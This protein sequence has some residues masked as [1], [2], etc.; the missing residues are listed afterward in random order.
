MTTDT[1]FLLD[2]DGPINGSNTGWS[3][4]PHKAWAYAK[5]KDKFY[6]MQ[7]SHHLIEKLR[8]FNIRWPETIYWATTWCGSTD[9]LERIFKLP[10]L[11]S[12]S[13]TAMSGDMKLRCAKMVI[14]NGDRLIWADDE[15]VPTSGSDYDFLTADG[16]ALLIKPKNS[17][18]RQG[19]RP[20]DMDNIFS[21]MERA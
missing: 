1:V 17:G 10:Q 19:I 20:E 21:F 6:K 18:R 8:E 15:Y 5:D 9:N 14:E 11:L 4:A 13:P 7:W 16:R 12:A 2:V 3:C